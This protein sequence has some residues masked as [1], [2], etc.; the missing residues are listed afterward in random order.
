MEAHLNAE[1]THYSVITVHGIRD[2][3]KTAWTNRSGVWWVREHL[4]KDLSIREIHYSYE[5]DEN[6]TLYQPDGIR[7]HA[8]RLVDEYTEIRK[9]LDE[10][11]PQ[12]YLAT[13]DTRSQ[14]IL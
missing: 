3:Y 5:I 12:D 9:K 6:S 7:I 1:L 2:D 11:C 13:L 10:V 4:F 14:L 8:E